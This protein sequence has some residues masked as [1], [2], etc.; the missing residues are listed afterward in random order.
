LRQGFDLVVIDGPSFLE[1]SRALLPAPGFSA[2]ADPSAE[3]VIDAAI[4]VRDA[5]L[6]DTEAT[7]RVMESLKRRGVTGLGVVENF[8]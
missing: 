8:V 5:R 3:P 7:F 1:S 6:A 4:V 2:S